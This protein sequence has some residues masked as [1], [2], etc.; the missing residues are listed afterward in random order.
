[1]IRQSLLSNGIRVVTDADQTLDTV[2]L[3]VW[4]GIGARYETP[5]VGGISH[6]LEHMAFKGTST[7]SAIQISRDVEN[8]G[9]VMNAYTGK[10]VTAYYVRLLKE[11]QALG[12]EILADILQDS[13]MFPDELAREKG[14]IVQEINMQNDTPD[15]LIY[16]H[17]SM[18]A[19][20]NQALGRPILGTA[21]TV[22]GI[23]SE[24]LSGYMHRRY[25]ADRIIISASGAVSHDMF[26]E[27]C[28]RLF[29]RISTHKDT[30]FEPARYVG[31]ESRVLKPHEQVNLVLGFEGCAYE[32]SAY[33]PAALAATVLG[34]GMSSRLFQEI[35]EKRGLVY[36]VYAHN[37]GELDTGILSVYA[38]TGEKEVVELMPVLCDVIIGMTDH[39]D[40]EELARAKAQLKSRVLMRL[41][42]RA[43][44]AESNALDL[45]F[46]GRLVPKEEILG[47][48]E[49][50]TVADVVD[51]S[52]RIL[53]TRPTLAVL[54]PVRDVMPY[55]HVCERLGYKS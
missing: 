38:G 33:Y 11:D 51:I 43:A 35:R 10:D 54:G 44:H 1:M 12:L 27:H 19:F 31:G 22:R 25:T 30:G 3:G 48:I 36:S 37:S 17:F 52:R 24:Q 49:S 29:T 26:A 5:D 7:R 8:V 20:P 53:K 18:T 45:V 2:S 41:E 42:N 15:E 6:M 32:D 50:T 21:Q 13:Q 40:E 4:V 46:K 14:V 9:G 55:E 34:G 23:S 47:K 39:V 28:E 16:D